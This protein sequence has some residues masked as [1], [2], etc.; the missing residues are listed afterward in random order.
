MDRPGSCYIAQVGILLPKCLLAV[1]ALM[2]M[3]LPGKRGALARD[4]KVQD[5]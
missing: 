3:V 1:S 4:F 2:S 5:N